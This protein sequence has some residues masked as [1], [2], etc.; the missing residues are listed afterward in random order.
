MTEMVTRRLSVPV[1]TYLNAG[2]PSKDYTCSASSF[3]KSKQGDIDVGAIFNNFTTHPL[4]RHAL[5][6][7]IINT[8]PEG[9]YEP[10][11]F[12]HFCALHFGGQPSP[13]L[14]CQAQWLILERCKGDRHDPQ[15]NWQWETV[16]LNLPGDINYNPLMP[17]LMLF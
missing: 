13:Y 8:R 12:W 16:H 17:C 5:G 2:S 15:N 4:E 1:A 14:A 11:E 9:E 6:V 7:R 10:H 3:V